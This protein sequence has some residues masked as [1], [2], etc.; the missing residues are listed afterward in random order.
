MQNRQ[1]GSMAFTLS[2]VVAI[3]GL[4]GMYLER[5]HATMLSSLKLV[6]QQ[7]ATA[8]ASDNAISSAGFF[9]ALVSP[10]KGADYVP[11][12]MA[13]NYYEQDWSLQKNSAITNANSELLNSRSVKLQLPVFDASA[14]HNIAEI[15]KG[16]QSSTSLSLR[17]SVVTIL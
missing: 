7:E 6:K 10:S 1:S 8:L 9:K 5:N 12:F 15:M 13:S 4:T 2:S 3:L 17:P 11:A 16:E 14:V